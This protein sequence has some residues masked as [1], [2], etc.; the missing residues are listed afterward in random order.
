MTSEA[1]STGGARTAAELV[2]TR[3][4]FF[5]RLFAGIIDL[6]ILGIPLSCFISFLSVGMGVSTAFLD[7]DPAKTPHQLLLKFGARFI[8]A[9][10]AFFVVISWAYFAGCESAKWQATPGKRFLGLMV[11]DE[12]GARPSF[13][14][15]TLRFLFGRA[16]FHIPYVGIYYVLV[17]CGRVAFSKD[18][19]AVHDLMAGC[20]VRR[21]YVELSETHR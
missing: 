4:A 21:S 13:Y 8:Y 6:L 14:K 1:I 18:G 12:N 16:L 17:D 5:P 2:P 9:S 10:L 11:T 7:L 19:R 20:L 15:A 3:P